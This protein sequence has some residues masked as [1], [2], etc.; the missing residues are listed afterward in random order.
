MSW[1][2]LILFGLI[3]GTAAGVG[4]LAG[5]LLCWGVAVAYR[6]IFR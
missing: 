2:V 1:G 5:R 6:R 4:A 3:T